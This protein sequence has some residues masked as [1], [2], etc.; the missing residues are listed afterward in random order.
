LGLKDR[1]KIFN[2]QFS[3]N[4]DNNVLFI[5]NKRRK[6][7]CGIAGVLFPKEVESTDINPAEI[8]VRMTA[9]QQHRGH[10]GAGAVMASHGKKGKFP[11]HKGLG[12]VYD[13]FTPEVIGQLSG[14]CGITHNRYS[15]T[16]GTSLSNIQPLT[17]IVGDG[18]N[19]EAIFVG[20]NGNLTSELKGVRPGTSDTWCIVHNFGA[21]NGGREIHWRIFQALKNVKGAF[22]LVFLFQDRNGKNSLIC[23][24]DPQGFRPLWLAKYKFKAEGKVKTGYLAA[25]ETCAFDMIEGARVWRPVKPG[26]IVVINEDGVRSFKPKAWRGQRLALCIFEYIYFTHPSSLAETDDFRTNPIYVWEIQEALGRQLALENPDLKADFVVGVPDSSTLHAQGLSRQSGI[27]P[28]RAILRNHPVGRTFI[29]P[30]GRKAEGAET[31]E[32]DAKI[33]RKFSLLIKKF[34]EVSSVVICDDSIVRGKTLRRIISFIRS[35]VKKLKRNLKIIVAIM[36]PPIKF[37]CF[38][39][40]DTPT[41]KELAWNK[42]SGSV[43]GVR[44]AIGADN[45]HY[46]SITGLLKTVETLTGHGKEKW[47]AAC[48]TGNYPT[49]IEREEYR[50]ELS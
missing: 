34:L 10:E 41:K 22:S 4:F 47:C 9:G 8:L 30:S 27:L 23:V 29:A 13:V 18:E 39:G 7:M 42:F 40:I 33:L 3:N 2:F 44:K 35:R 31:D 5:S 6:C 15:T 19:A 17:G 36:S 11:E 32:R 1:E 20:H 45:L 21:V 48:F 16:G 14:H 46:L 24:R 26:E 12:L 37:P 50:K 43:E 28:D 25:S 49:D 38:F